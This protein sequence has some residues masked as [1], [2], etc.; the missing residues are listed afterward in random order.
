[1]KDTNKHNAVLREKKLTK[2]SCVGAT[3]GRVGT[4]QS[5]TDKLTSVHLLGNYI[6]I[7]VGHLRHNAMLDS[8]ADIPICHKTGM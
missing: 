8:G 1:V 5:P 2:P 7:K 3:A 4:V 6:P